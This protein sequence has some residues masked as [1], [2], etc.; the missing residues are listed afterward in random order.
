MFR[1]HSRDC[2]KFVTFANWAEYMNKCKPYYDKEYLVHDTP[3]FE[4]EFFKPNSR[5][6]EKSVVSSALR[7]H[8]SALFRGK[9]RMKELEKD[10]QILLQ[11]GIATHTITNSQ[12]I[13]VTRKKHQKVRER[14]AVVKVNKST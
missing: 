3:D 10:K 12:G 14:P 7:Y 8:K 13:K 6:I 2:R 1:D 9:N 11:G 4:L 5:L